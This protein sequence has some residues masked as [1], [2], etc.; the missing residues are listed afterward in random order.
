MALRVRVGPLGPDAAWAGANQGP[1]RTDLR[2]VGACR[3]TVGWAWVCV[4]G[5]GLLLVVLWGCCLCQGLEPIDTILL[6][7]D[8]RLT[9][10]AFV[11]LPGNMQV[12]LALQKN[13]SYMGRRYIEI[14]KA[15][16]AVGGEHVA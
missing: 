7:R 12:D 15:K 14:Y 13:R 6:K 8:G 4:P 1:R 3:P 10:E 16:K 5:S 2:R 11:L 9:G